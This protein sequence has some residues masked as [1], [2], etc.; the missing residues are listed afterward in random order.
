MS[1]FRRSILA[2][3]SMALVLTAVRLG[4]WQLDRLATR[5]DA[6][7]QL[8]VARAQPPIDLADTPPVAGRRA[9]ARGQFETEGQLLLRNRVHRAAPGLH[10]VTPFRIEGRTG[11]I[12]VLRGFV[13]AADGVRPDS[14][15]S[16]TPGS[17][18]ISG[19]LQPLPATDN[20]G[21]PVVI[22]GDT[23][24]RR[25][26]AAVARARRSDAPPMVL[27]LAGGDAGP[28]QLPVVEPPVLDDG[29]H[30]SYALQWFA[31]AIAIG[32]FGAFAFRTPTGRAPA[33]P[34]GAP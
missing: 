9:S 4:V 20:T 18:R 21:Q 19:E 5:R 34:A 16:P 1:R 23:T 12:W 28:G 24:W 14:I 26:D 30:L 17:V 7:R 3:I 15:P 32:V 2:V 6:N 31:I 10:V 29:P 22:D 13:P 8:L 33:P 27:Y 25:L 11:I